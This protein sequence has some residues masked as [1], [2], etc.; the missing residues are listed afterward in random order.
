MT[1]AQLV[2]PK[3]LQVWLKIEETERIRLVGVCAA[4]IDV[5][6]GVP[7]DEKEVIE[8]E[9]MLG[10]VQGISSHAREGCRAVLAVTSERMRAQSVGL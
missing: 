1:R 7:L 4:V 10:G 9:S 6:A 3:Q 5:F 2:L 8:V